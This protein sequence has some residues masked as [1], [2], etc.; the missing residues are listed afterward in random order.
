MVWE[1]EKAARE[2][3]SY[4]LNDVYFGHN[5]CANKYYEKDLCI[6]WEMHLNIKQKCVVYSLG[7]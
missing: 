3:T 1:C 5:F 2:Y 7:M 6:L 4:F